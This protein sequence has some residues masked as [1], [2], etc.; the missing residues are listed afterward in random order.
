MTD[1]VGVLSLK[2]LPYW[3]AVQPWPGQYLYLSVYS[4]NYCRKNKLQYKTETESVVEYI[5]DLKLDNYIG[6]YAHKDV[7]VFTDSGYD[8]KKIENAMAR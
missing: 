7:I 4:K 3:L 5:T 1:S 6:P 2:V 8:D